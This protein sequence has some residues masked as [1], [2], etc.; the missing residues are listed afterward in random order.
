M[1]LLAAAF[2]NDRNPQRAAAEEGSGGIL[3][4]VGGNRS[5]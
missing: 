2:L 4:T 5:T 3:G 1:L